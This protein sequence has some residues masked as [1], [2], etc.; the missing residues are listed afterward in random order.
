MLVF[1]SGAGLVC[2]CCKEA[3]PGPEPAECIVFSG[4]S[5]TRGSSIN[6]G[7]LEEVFGSQGIE[8]RA[9]HDGTDYFRQDERIFCLGPGLWATSDS[10]YWPSDAGD[11][12]NFWAWAFEKESKAELSGIA[13]TD[14]TLKFTYRMAEPSLDGADALAQRELLLAGFKGASRKDCPQGVPLGFEHALSAVK[15]K[16]GRANAGVLGSIRLKNIYS[17]AEC[18]YSGPGQIE[19]SSHSSRKDF[20]QQFNLQIQGNL[21]EG[22]FQDVNAGAQADENG[23]VFMV[24]PQQLQDAGIELDYSLAGKDNV[25]V[26]T[27]ALEGSWEA[28]RSYIYTLSILGGL[29]VSIDGQMEGLSAG[30]IGF[31]NN[32]ECPC[33]LRATMLGCWENG[34]AEIVQPA[35]GEDN[36]VTRDPRWADFWF[37]DPDSHIYYYRYPLRGGESVAVNLIDSFRAGEGPAETHL[38]M[39]VMVQ[40]I[41]QDAGLSSV[42]AAIGDAGGYVDMLY[43]D[44][45]EED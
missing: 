38:N 17:E 18:T 20:C 12:L 28:G 7:K 31:T 19:W 5:A 10:Y 2:G 44:F 35:S 36:T 9:I 3:M 6:G 15:I 39:T 29:S 13:A 45:Y 41:K 40:A 8:I 14:S 34:S 11:A 16:V 33:Y 22:N 26:F 27:S 32:G 24:I 42:R 1:L 30:S 25:E 23:T 37:F 4:K 43:T 21:Y